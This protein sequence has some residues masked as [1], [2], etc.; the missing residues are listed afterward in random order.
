VTA[1]AILIAVL[2]STGPALADCREPEAGSDRAPLLSPPLGE[3]AIGTGRLQFYAAPS[4]RCPIKGVFVIP[5][6]ALVAYAR[7]DDGW[8]S[9]MYTHPRTGD[10]VNG[11][12]R[13]SRLKV[14]GTMGPTYTDDD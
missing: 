8:T 4:S 2:L 14:T 7:T 3:V 1:R 11:W 10:H 9:V 6:D 12:V 5:R 13:S